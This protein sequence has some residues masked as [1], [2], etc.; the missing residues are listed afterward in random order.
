MTGAN[1]AVGRCLL[2]ASTGEGLGFVACVRSDRAQAELPPLGPSCAVARV[3]Y[4]DLASLA[5]AFRGCEAVIHL[6]GI[7]IERPGSSYEG[8]NVETTRAVVAAAQKVGARRLV[9]VSAI[10]AD[11]VSRNRYYARTGR[12]EALVRDSGLRWTV[13]R[14][15]LVLGPGT[16]GSRA[17]LRHARGG[18]AWLLGGGRNLQQ[19]LAVED[20]ARAALYA[21]RSDVASGRVLD[22][23]GPEALAERELIERTARLLGREVSIRALP[24]GLARGAAALRTRIAGPGFSPDAIEV[25]TANTSRPPVAAAEL[26]LEL[27]SV[28]QMLER[29]ARAED[30]G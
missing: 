9:L 6:P 21:A 19:P 10:G 14:A 20:L 27:A 16:E 13:L 11:P 7:L 26:G 28:D 25:I 23:V 17:L 15:P 29:G 12:A 5:E 2:A 18:R 1:S 3:S 4:D 22:L 8:A 24:I 30:G